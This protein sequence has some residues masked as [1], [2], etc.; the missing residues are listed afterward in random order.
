M[1]LIL[2]KLKYISMSSEKNVS[3]GNLYV[4]IHS[5]LLVE[6][7]SL[8]ICASYKPMEMLLEF[9]ACPGLRPATLAVQPPAALLSSSPC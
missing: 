3:N 2:S 4:P 8:L 1:K 5:S 9:P 6:L 7:R